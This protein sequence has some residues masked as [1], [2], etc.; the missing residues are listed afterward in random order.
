MV[1]TRILATFQTGPRADRLF[2]HFCEISSTEMWLT[3]QSDAT[4]PD[5]LPQRQPFNRAPHQF[6]A[7][8]PIPLAL[9]HTL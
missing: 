1:A 7:A 2:A 5:K 8:D 9:W 6:D 4:N 3:L